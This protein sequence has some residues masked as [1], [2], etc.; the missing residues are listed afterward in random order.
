MFADVQ[1]SVAIAREEIFG[2]VLSIFAYVHEKTTRSGLHPYGLAGFATSGVLK[3]RPGFQ[4]NSIRKRSHRW[5]TVRFW[6]LFWSVQTV[7]QW[8]AMG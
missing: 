8:S 5:P 7:G 2:P 4:A 3:R 1:K 6:Q